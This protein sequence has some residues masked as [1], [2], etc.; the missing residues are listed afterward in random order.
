MWGK[1]FVL[2]I[3]GEAFSK[4]SKENETNF[5]ILY[6]NWPFSLNKV[7]IPFIISE[8]AWKESVKL[9]SIGIYFCKNILVY[10]YIYYILLMSIELIN[11]V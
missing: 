4:I 1:Q 5:I 11:T 2:L 10:T 9:E 7:Y 3:K 8:C 6:W